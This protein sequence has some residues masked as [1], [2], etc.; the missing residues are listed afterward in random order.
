MN[1]AE[2]L[3]R[4][5]LLNWRVH[6]NHHAAK[7]QGLGFRVE[8]NRIQNHVLTGRTTPVLD[9]VACTVWCKPKTPKF[10]HS[11]KAHEDKGFGHP[12]TTIRRTHEFFN[13]LHEIFLFICQEDVAQR[14]QVSVYY[15]LSAPTYLLSSYYTATWTLWV[16]VYIYPRGP[17]IG[18]KVPI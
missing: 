6:L 4:F 13:V 7:S 17:Y 3:E 18:P 8:D 2:T 15:R 12:A 10:A 11:P 14:V 1:L 9:R 16:V 5:G